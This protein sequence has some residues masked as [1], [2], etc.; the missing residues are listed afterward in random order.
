MKQQRR[1]LDARLPTARE[2]AHRLMKHRVGQL[3]LPGDFA[4]PP[5]GL[6]AV[7]DEK[8]HHGF[9]VVKRIVLAKITEAQFLAP[10]DLAGVERF[11]AQQHAAERTLARAVA[12]DQP[13]FLII[14]E[15]TTGAVEQFLLAIAL[16][17]VLKL[18]YNGHGCE[19]RRRRD[20]SPAARSAAQLDGG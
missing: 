17:G 12:T 14:L 16:M 19:G 9:A 4:A 2:R 6:L 13:D 7:A 8:P 3:K 15:R 10:H 20:P 18:Q 11:I 1:N 5:V